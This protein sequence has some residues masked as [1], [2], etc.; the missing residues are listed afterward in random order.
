[1]RSRRFCILFARAFA[2][3]SVNA[4]SLRLRRLRID[5]RSVV[6]FAGFRVLA[7][8]LVVLCFGVFLLPSNLRERLRFR[9]R[10][11]SGVLFGGLYRLGRDRRG[12]LGW[13]SPSTRSISHCV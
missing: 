12:G 1:M 13:R 9:L 6:G 2:G 4:G 10:E 8:G 5:V 3:M 7:V 11:A